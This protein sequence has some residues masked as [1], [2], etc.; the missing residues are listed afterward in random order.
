MAIQIIILLI[1]SAL[2]I[3]LLLIKYENN[4]LETLIFNTKKTDEKNKNSY[5]QE[6]KKTG[7]NDSEY[8]PPKNEWPRSYATAYPRKGLA[9]LK[10]RFSANAY[11]PDGWITQMS[12]HITG[13]NGFSE[14]S[15][16]WHPEYTF[17]TP[18]EYRA[19][20]TVRDDDWNT[21]ASH[22]FVNVYD[23]SKPAR[24]EMNKH[25]PFPIKLVSSKIN[26]VNQD[27]VKLEDIDY[28]ITITGGLINR[29]DKKETGTI[30]VLKANENIFIEIPRVWFA[31]G[32]ATLKIEFEIPDRENIKEEHTILYMGNLFVIT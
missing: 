15:Y 29:L 11:D 13:P 1:V 24:V 5:D 25:Y 26:F 14:Y 4:S 3:S 19:I 2:T 17:E 32:R 22:V 12:W 31:F 27:D 28:K 23:P 16:H 9:P 20:L 18:G 6:Y 7:S 21:D 30:D 10:V 8:E